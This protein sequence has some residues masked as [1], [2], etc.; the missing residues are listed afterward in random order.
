MLSRTDAATGTVESFQFFLRTAVVFGAGTVER[1]G[2]LAQQLAMTRTLLVADPGLLTSGH[3]DRAAASLAEVGIAVTPFH[4]FGVNPDSNMV[5]A[6]RQVAAVAAVDSIVALG[7]GSS[8]DCA[9][10]INFVLSNGGTM[11]DYWGHGKAAG[12]MLPVDWHPDDRR[13]RQRS[14]ELRHH[15]R[16]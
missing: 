16:R 3:V 13:N 2:E 12:P 6:G 5:E 1:L 15:F 9:K 4:D 7:G 8:L 11:R 10:G 14:P